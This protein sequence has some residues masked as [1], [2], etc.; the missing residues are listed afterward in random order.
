VP[1]VNNLDLEVAVG[2]V[3]HK[4]NV[5][6]GANSI[7]GGTTDTK[8]NVESVFLPAGTAGNFTVTEDVSLPTSFRVDDVSVK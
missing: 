3:T 4:G 7:S 6:S 5:F 8:N 1:S 2:G